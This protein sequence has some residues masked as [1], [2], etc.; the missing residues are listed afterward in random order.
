[1]LKAFLYAKIQVEIIMWL[2]LELRLMIIQKLKPVTYLL[3]QLQPVVKILLK[4]LLMV[5]PQTVGCY[6]VHI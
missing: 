1:M 2:F 3:W 4:Q 5:L 6:L